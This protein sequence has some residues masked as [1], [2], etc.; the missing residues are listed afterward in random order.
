MAKL[1]AELTSDKGGRKA[2]KGGNEI[3][4]IEI[5][6]GNSNIISIDYKREEHELHINDDTENLMVNLDG[7]TVN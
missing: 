5:F 4:T 2:S 3:I 7:F 1:Y 6:D